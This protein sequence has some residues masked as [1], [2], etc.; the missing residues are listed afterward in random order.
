MDTI[1]ITNEM[2]ISTMICSQHFN[3][4][5]DVSY[6]N[7]HHFLNDIMFF[8]EEYNIVLISDFWGRKLI[9]AIL[10]KVDGILEGRSDVWIPDG[11]DGDAR[12]IGGYSTRKKTEIKKFNLS[13]DIKN[14]VI[15]QW[16]DELKRHS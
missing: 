8:N 1:N 11:Y 12:S 2:K 10:H 3:Q 13:D 5:E 16:K 14:D 9:P 6:Y 7:S 15:N 4:N